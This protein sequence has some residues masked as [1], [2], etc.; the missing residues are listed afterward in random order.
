MAHILKPW[1][2]SRHHRK[3]PKWDL[4]TPR[5]GAGEQK[6][7]EPDME[8]VWNL[9]DPPEEPWRVD[10]TLVALVAAVFVVVFVAG[11]VWLF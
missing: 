3:T 5:K 9:A 6:P 8:P 11:F 7:A 2:G 4:G 1:F 10:W